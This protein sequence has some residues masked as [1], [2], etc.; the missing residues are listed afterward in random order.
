MKD[1]HEDVL[2]TAA[3]FYLTTIVIMELVGGNG[4][5]NDPKNQIHWPFGVKASPIV[6]L[7]V[8][9]IYIAF[10][11]LQFVLALGN[12]PKGCVLRFHCLSKRVLT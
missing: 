8:Q 6:N 12:R 9:Y 2:T 4:D 5:E 3:S 11:V 10:L 1:V 7:I